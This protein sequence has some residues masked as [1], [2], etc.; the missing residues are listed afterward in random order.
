[1]N[2]AVILVQSFHYVWISILGM[3]VANEV[4]VQI[5]K[6]SEWQVPAKYLTSPQ[7][8][9]PSDDQSTQSH[10][11]LFHCIVLYCKLSAVCHLPEVHDC[12]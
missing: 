2:L 11:L 12:P 7:S 4:H 3:M 10:T 8:S 6:A 9:V 1:M 5:F